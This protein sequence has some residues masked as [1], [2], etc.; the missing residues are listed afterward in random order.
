MTGAGDQGRRRAVPLDLRRHVAPVGDLWSRSLR[1]PRHLRSRHHR[2]HR[3]RDPRGQEAA[4]G[5]RILAAEVYTADAII[6][7]VVS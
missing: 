7:T 1:P 3:A 6:R 2:T 5:A 4:D